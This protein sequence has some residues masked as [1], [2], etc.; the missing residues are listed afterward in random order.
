MTATGGVAL[1]S[2]AGGQNNF[3]NGVFLHASLKAVDIQIFWSDAVHWRYATTQ[4]MIHAFELTGVFNGNQLADS[5]HNV[6]TYPI[7][8]W[9]SEKTSPMG[10][11]SPSLSQAGMAHINTL[12]IRKLRIFISKSNPTFFVKNTRR[13]H[14]QIRL[15]MRA[16]K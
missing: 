8:A 4:D 11:E 16:A 10:N 13:L 3:G 12:Y 1:N 14:V 15:V 6:S 7:T 2:G 9:L 5:L